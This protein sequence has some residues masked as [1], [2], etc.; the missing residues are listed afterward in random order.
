MIRSR[1]F[2]VRACARVRKFDPFSADIAS[3]TDSSHRAEALTLGT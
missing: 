2:N 3:A 1:Q